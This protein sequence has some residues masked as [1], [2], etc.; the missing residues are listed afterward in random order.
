M[1]GVECCTQIK[2]DECSNFTTVNRTNDIIPD[3][4][5]S[6]FRVVMS[7]VSLYRLIQ[8]K[9]FMTSISICSEPRRNN[10]S[11]LEAKLKFD[12]GRYE[13]AYSTSN[14]GFLSR[15]KPGLT[16]AFL[17][18]LLTAATHCKSHSVL[19]QERR[20]HVSRANS[21]L[22]RTNNVWQVSEAAVG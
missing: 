7:A 5:Y 16:C 6:S 21:A 13:L 9:Q 2:Q 1:H 12:I 14:V 20:K 3:T 11:N 17:E 18:D 15:G 8:W 10:S 22:D 19:E 4:H